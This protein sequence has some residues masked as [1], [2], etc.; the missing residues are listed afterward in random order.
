MTQADRTTAG[1]AGAER[2]WPMALAVL[3]AIVLSETRPTGLVPPLWRIVGVLELILLVVLLLVDPGRI[4]RRG[5]WVRRAS[6]ALVSLLLADALASTIGLAHHILDGSPPANDARDLLLAGGQVWLFT[7]VVFGLLYWEL[8][9]GGSANRTHHPSR[10]RD[11]AFPQDF[12][13]EVAPRGWSARFH[14]YLYLGL[15]GALAFSPT[16][17]MPLTFRAKFFMAVESLVSVAIL[18][19]VVARAVNVLQ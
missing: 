3:V 16:D 7:I 1:V 2:R 5:V 8:D 15:T 14:D 13:P 17:A 11:F 19:L 4:D 6:I 18:T 9:G 10:R 12:T